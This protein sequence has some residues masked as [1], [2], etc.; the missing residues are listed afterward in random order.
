M[1][2]A[3][4]TATTR[5]TTLTVTS[6]RT[7]VTFSAVAKPA[8]IRRGTY[9]LTV[10]IS[11]A[12]RSPRSAVANIDDAGRITVMGALRHTV[13]RNGHLDD[14]SIT[15]DELAEIVAGVEFMWSKMA[16]DVKGARMVSMLHSVAA[17]RAR[18]ESDT[19]ARFGSFI[20]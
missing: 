3:T 19:A 7:G 1:N 20:A 17:L 12:G 8:D 18:G 2:T 9:T 4:A 6:P 14:I 11:K 15:G 5:E 16:A 13:M 10:G